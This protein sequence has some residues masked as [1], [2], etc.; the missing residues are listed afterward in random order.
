MIRSVDAILVYLVLVEL[1]IQTLL[2]CREQ[3]VLLII[4]AHPAGLMF[5]TAHVTAGMARH[6]DQMTKKSVVM[7]KVC[8]MGQIAIH[9][10]QKSEEDKQGQY[11]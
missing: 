1:R 8:L 6:Y 10:D 5:S 2:V 3:R 4:H 9:Y 11:E 7:A